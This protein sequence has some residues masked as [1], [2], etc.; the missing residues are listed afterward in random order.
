MTNTQGRGNK[1]PMPFLINMKETKR[2]FEKKYTPFIEQVAKV[3]LLDSQHPIEL[4]AKELKNSWA[5]FDSAYP[6]KSITINYSQEL[7]KEP[8][9]K[10]KDV[11][12]HEMC[13]ALT[14]PLYLKGNSRYVTTDE[15]NDVREELTDHLANVVIKNKLI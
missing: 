14:D 11:L 4:K 7:T 10:I 15:L 8:D 6:Y 9:R 5:T 2:H 12:I 1:I 13:H 3:L